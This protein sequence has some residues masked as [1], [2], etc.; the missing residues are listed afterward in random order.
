MSGQRKRI[1]VPRPEPVVLPD[2]TP[3]EAAQ[4]EAMLAP[5][6]NPD[7]TPENKLRWAYHTIRKM[8]AEQASVVV[9]SNFINSTE[10]IELVND[11]TV[12][13]LLRRRDGELERILEGP[14]ETGYRRS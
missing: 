5:M 12:Y 2:P 1:E 3:E 6:R 14:N 8:V 10:F 4:I 9:K 11:E 7:A 13:R